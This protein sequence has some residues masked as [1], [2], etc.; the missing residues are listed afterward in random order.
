[1]IKRKVVEEGEDR[2]PILA[3]ALPL[4]LRKSFDYRLKEEDYHALTSG[5]MEST[6]LVGRR[7]RV[8]F[9]NRQLIGMIVEIKRE[10][11]WPLEK[12]KR[13][14]LIDD[15]PLISGSLLQL[16]FWMS[17]YYHAPIGEVMTLFLPS[18]LRQ[19]EPLYPL[20][21][22][23]QIGAQ[24]KEWLADEKHKRQ[25]VKYPLVEWAMEHLPM[26]ESAIIA[27]HPNFLVHAR[28]LEKS[29]ILKSE[30]VM[31]RE[32]EYILP[33]PQL[34]ER[35]TLALN[36]EQS[37]AL[38]SILAHEKG[39]T[40]LEGVTGSGKTAVYIEVARAHLKRG[41]QVLFL[42]P[43]IGLTAQFMERLEQ[44]LGVPYGVI[45]SHLSDEERLS[46]W[47]DARS[48]ALSLLVGTRSALLT[49]FKNLGLIVIDE[50]HDS[51]YLQRDGVRYSAHNSA[52]MRAHLESIPTILGSATPHLEL[53]HHALNGHYHHV[54][55]TER[56]KGSMPSWEVIDCNHEQLFEGLSLPLLNAIE[57]RLEAGEQSLLF[58][59]RRGFSPILYCDDCGAMAECDHCS[60]YLNYHRTTH[61]LHCHHC[62]TKRPLPQVCQRCGGAH[63]SFIG[64]G[65][66]RLEKV[67][68]DAFPQAKVLRF[69]RDSVRNS[70]DFET[71][72]QLVIDNR[73][74][75][76][77]GTQM[78]AKGHDF[79]NI[80]LVGLI[81]SDG[82]FFANDFRA[83]ERLAQLLM[84]VSGRAGRGERSGHLMIQSYFP[85]H[86]LFQELPKI[87]YRAYLESLLPLREML[88]LPPYSHQALVQA[89]AKSEGEAE[90]YLK[91]VIEASG[92]GAE[93][94]LQQMPVMPMSMHRRQGYYRAYA[95]LQSLERSTL[96]RAV[97]TLIATVEVNPRSDIRFIVEIDPQEMG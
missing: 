13:A 21:R 51:S 66:Q 15:A 67:L 91:G 83:E 10:A 73:A 26:E 2:E 81:N 8:P 9:G 62:A 64:V 31:K 79:P 45:H 3:V 52:L 36:R 80:T 16:M 35:G 96:H 93:E 55:L 7:V 94:N 47:R 30:E 42:V 58:L 28:P 25:R 29:G 23:W 14:T 65:T 24:A 59:N 77:I 27:E 5:A 6:S 76:I 34:K 90:H 38:D 92:I 68:R 44:Q 72:R 48:G 33:S 43:E 89:E 70:Y 60:A 57:A 87:G 11:D 22:I 63:L 39:V 1:M 19:G 49:P 12:I 95:L 46:A 88:S 37:A 53:L 82:F 54:L 86:E 78:I 71:Q 69:D 74:D 50:A 97:S 4:P 84:Q 75:I 85:E 20:E 18:K 32:G 41:E 61:L 17:R 40:L 56:A